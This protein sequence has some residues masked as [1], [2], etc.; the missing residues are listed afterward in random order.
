MSLWRVWYTNGALDYGWLASEHG[1]GRMGI[2]ESSEE[3]AKAQAD[4]ENEAAPLVVHRAWAWFIYK[5]ISPSDTDGTRGGWETIMQ[6]VEIEE[7]A[8]MRMADTM[9]ADVQAGRR[10]PMKK[11]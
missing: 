10:L 7:D 3:H 1:N 6:G 2:F 4:A 9:L 5:I 8:A 11:L